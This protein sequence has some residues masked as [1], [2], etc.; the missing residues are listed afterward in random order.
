V[1]G[2]A[3]VG[4][5]YLLRD[6]ATGVVKRT[7]RTNNLHR[8]ELELNRGKKTKDLDF[9]AAYR[10]DSYDEQRGLEQILYDNHPSALPVNGG[11]NYVR[12]VDPRRKELAE[13][14]M[15]AAQVYLR[16]MGGG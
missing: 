8:R 13:R 6:S 4:G 10:T 15:N 12:G 1:R 14:Y 7:G 11:L 5:A 2:D 16:A 3:A 9:E